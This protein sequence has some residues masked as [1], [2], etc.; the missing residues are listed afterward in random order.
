MSS[1]SSSSSSSF[2]SLKSG[3]KREREIVNHIYRKKTPVCICIYILPDGVLGNGDVFN[4]GLSFTEQEGGVA[5]LAQD[6]DTSAF[7]AFSA[8]SKGF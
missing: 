1:S 5:L 7:S 3:G 6:M 2:S 4:C 8:S